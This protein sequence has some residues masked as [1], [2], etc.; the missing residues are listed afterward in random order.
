MADEI[1]VPL[2]EQGVSTDSAGSFGRD[3][4]YLVGGAALGVAVLAAGNAVF[5]A[6]KETFGMS[7]DVSIPT[8]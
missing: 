5:N 4:G 3:V 2:F 1:P 6:G 7:D 8:I